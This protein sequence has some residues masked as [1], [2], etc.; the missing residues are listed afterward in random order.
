M[1]I[2][3]LCIMNVSLETLPETDHVLRAI[4]KIDP[5]GKMKVPVWGTKTDRA[6]PLYNAGSVIGFKDPATGDYFRLD[7]DP[8]LGLHLNYVKNIIKPGKGG[9]KSDNIHV[10][11]MKPGHGAQELKFIFWK[12][13]T[14]TAKA[15]FFY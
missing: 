11:I 3:T 12:R 5:A 15:K 1:L 10:Q 4:K 8:T 9:R 14:T 6:S 2:S 7:Y 13:W